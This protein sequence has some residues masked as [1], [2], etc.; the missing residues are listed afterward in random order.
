MIENKV[1][2]FLSSVMGGG[3]ERVFISIANDFASKGMNVDLVLANGKGPY[4]EEI[5]DLVNVVDL[6]CRQSFSSINQ[7]SLYLNNI[8]PN[9]FFST[10]MHTNVVALL[11]LM[12]SRHKPMVIL[13]EANALEAYRTGF[14]NRIVLL[15]ARFLYK[16]ADKIIALHEAMKKEIINAFHITDEKITVINNPVSIEK[17]R[18]LSKKENQ[19]KLVTGGNKYILGIGRLDQQKDFKTLILAYDK[20][21]KEFNDIKLVI[22][23]EGVLFLE[24]EKQIEKLGLS[25]QVILPGFIPNPFPWIKSAEMLVSTS[26]FE[27]FPNVLI[28]ALALDVSVIATNCPGASAEILEYGKLGTLIAIG[29]VND[30]AKAIKANL[31]GRKDPL[32]SARLE[33]SISKYNVENIS[34]QYNLL[35]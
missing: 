15:L 6:S 34:A 2:F 18:E 11:A 5:S 30:L 21:Y 14:K 25:N 10:Q 9:V 16:K 32:F 29:D 3:A 17:I 12:I 22:L 4:L 31:M 24:I 26:K 8:K 20:V 28:Q 27:G 13:R 23:G 1:T 33:S 7:L 19:I 35:F